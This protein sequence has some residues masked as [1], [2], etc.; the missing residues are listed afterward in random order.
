[1]KKIEKSNYN[2]HLYF[3]NPKEMNRDELNYLIDK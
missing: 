3:N 1:M 2:D